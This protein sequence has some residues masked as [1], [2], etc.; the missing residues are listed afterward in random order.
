MSNRTC[1]GCTACCKLLPMQAQ[2]VDRYRTTIEALVAAGLMQASVLYDSMA[3]FNKPAG[4]P[5]P[6]QRF[7][8]GCAVYERRPFGCRVWNCRWLSEDDTADLSRPDRSHVV[9]DISPDFVKGDNELIIPVIQIW[10]DPG[11]RD[12]YKDPA[13]QAYLIRRAAEGYAAL[14]R[15][16]GEADCFFLY[17][18]GEKFCEKR[19]GLSGEHA[20]TALEKAAALGGIN[21]TLTAN[22]RQL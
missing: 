16:N 19:T 22:R 11:Y 14:I 18:D 13:L 1:G 5:C 6:H 17:Y 20:H 9:V 15:Y 4:Q 8:K 2:A 7:K 12:A 10:C 3:D 21:I